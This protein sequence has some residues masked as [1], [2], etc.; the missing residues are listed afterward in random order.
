M[1]TK[2]PLLPVVGKEEHQLFERLVVAAPQG[3][4]NFEQI[5]IEWCKKV[6]A[7]N[8]FPKLP[9]Y[10]RTHYSKWQRNQRV[11]DAVDRAA[12]GEARLR[13][14]NVVFGTQSTA[15]S[16]ATVVSVLLPPTMPQPQGTWV[17]PVLGVIVG[18]TMVG[19]APPT[20]GDD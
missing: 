20:R 13:E 8:I 17:Q 18:G 2:L 12:L 3:P 7:V 10:L 6:D 5:A 4:L 15:A 11:R 16:E 19:G 14:I 9:V 1:N